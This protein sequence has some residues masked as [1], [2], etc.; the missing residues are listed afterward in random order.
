[1]QP[2]IDVSSEQCQ[3][4]K[5]SSNGPQASL[6]NKSQP[7]T[8]YIKFYFDKQTWVQQKGFSL[9]PGCCTGLHTHMYS[10]QVTNDLICEGQCPSTRHKS[11]DTNIPAGHVF[12]QTLKATLSNRLL[13][14]GE[15][16]RWCHLVVKYLLLNPTTQQALVPIKTH[17]CV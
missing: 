5:Q 13:G 8:V 17:P 6:S 1:M 3:N 7:K 11:A 2:F 12:S 15:R 4:N 9:R 16:A 14:G 10:G